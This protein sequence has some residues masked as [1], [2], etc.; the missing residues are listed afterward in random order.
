MEWFVY[1]IETIKG[2]FYTGIT[3][4]LQKRF[5][6][7][8]EGKSGAKFFRLDPPKRILWSEK[9]LNRSSATKRESELKKLTRVQKID[10]IRKKA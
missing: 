4:D 2:K 7:H 5:N 1:I 3:N 9:H 8:K 6:S 10:L